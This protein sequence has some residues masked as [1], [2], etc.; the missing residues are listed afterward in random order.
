[1]FERSRESCECVCG[2]GREVLSPQRARLNNVDFET[3]R[4]FAQVAAKLEN[5]LQPR[6]RAT[7]KMAGFF[8]FEIWRD[9]DSR[10]FIGRQRFPYWTWRHA[11]GFKAEEG[12][13]PFQPWLGA[14]FC[15]LADLD[16][17]LMRNLP[18]RPQASRMTNKRNSANVQRRTYLNGHAS[19]H[20]F[21]IFLPSTCS[22]S[23][24]IISS[25]STF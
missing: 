21:V 19:L 6:I 22:L 11:I 7:H 17:F 23:H 20:H 10:H 9:F 1:M 4:C 5:G 24:L 25:F 12:V 13:H 18:R 16:E 3:W 14:L 8:G 15:P 2:E